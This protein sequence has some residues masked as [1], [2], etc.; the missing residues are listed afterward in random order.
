MTIYRGV[1]LFIAGFML[2]QMLGV[3]CLAQSQDSSKKA[4][5]QIE[6]VECKLVTTTLIVEVEVEVR[7]QAGQIVPDLSREDFIAIEDGV[8]QEVAYLLAEDKT[9]EN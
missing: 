7:D 1:T 5:D 9:D 6:N 3:R 2:L 8:R 4:K